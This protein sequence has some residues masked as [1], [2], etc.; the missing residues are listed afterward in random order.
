MALWKE[1]RHR[2]KL[3]VLLSSAECKGYAKFTKDKI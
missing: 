1:K 2:G 3:K